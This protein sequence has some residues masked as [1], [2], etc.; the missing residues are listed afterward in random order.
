M[1]SYVSASHQWQTNECINNGA[2][3]AR[4]DLS[5]SVKLNSSEAHILLL[6]LRDA[7]LF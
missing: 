1:D 3:Q 7:R 2:F 4:S 6:T 5:F